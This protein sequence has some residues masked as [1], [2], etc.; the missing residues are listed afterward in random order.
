VV[1]AAQNISANRG[2]KL[3]LCSNRGCGFTVHL[4]PGFQQRAQIS[5]CIYGDWQPTRT[6]LYS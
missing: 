6:H 4:S 2:R 3:L 1:T 5:T